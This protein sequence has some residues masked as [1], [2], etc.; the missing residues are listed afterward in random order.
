VAITYEPIATT[1]LS[2]DTAEITFSSIPSS[3]TDL[4]LVFTPKTQYAGNYIWLRFNTD[5]DANYSRSVLYL[6]GSSFGTFH[7]NAET[8]I[9][10]N[11]YTPTVGRFAL[12]DADIFA[13][14]S[15]S[16]KKTILYSGI[17]DNN[18]SGYLTRGVAMWSSSSAI[19][20]VTLTTDGGNIL[21][22][23]VATLYGIKAA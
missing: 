2:S 3:Y 15:S 13:Y 12:Y 17:E 4:R 18:G 6:D 9:R 10:M 21:S 1:T 19:T 23:T 5:T 20:S 7:G 14:S 8:K 16:A 22:G 11:F